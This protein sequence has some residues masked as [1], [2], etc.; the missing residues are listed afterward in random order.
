MLSFLPNNNIHRV[1]I[2]FTI[3]SGFYKSLTI[4]HKNKFSKTRVTTSISCEAWRNQTSILGAEKIVVAPTPDI[5]TDIIS[6]WVASLL[7]ANIYLWKASQIYQIN[8]HKS[9]Y[10]KA[11]LLLYILIIHKSYFI[12]SYYMDGSKHVDDGQSY[13]KF[14]KGGVYLSWVK[15]FLS[16]L[17][18]S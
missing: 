5:R 3:S 7:T 6:Y 18:R 2:T 4:Q 1:N 15:G 13:W 14:R 11:K 16:S 10:R 12:I 9:K 17:L 8:V